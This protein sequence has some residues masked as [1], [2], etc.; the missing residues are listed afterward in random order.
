[1]RRA[2]VFDIVLAMT[3]SQWETQVILASY[4]YDKLFRSFGWGVGSARQ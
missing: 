3:N 1:L 4:M 2:Q